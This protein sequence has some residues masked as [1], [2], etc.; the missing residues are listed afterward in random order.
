MSASSYFA[1]QYPSALCSTLI[2]LDFSISEPMELVVKA[3]RE[4]EFGS[5]LQDFLFENFIPNKVISWPKDEAEV[6]SLPHVAGQTEAG[7]TGDIGQGGTLF[8]CR[9]KTC[10]APISNLEKAKKQILT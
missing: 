7:K 2:A 10:L 1:N 4:K 9:N 3:S 6:D 8:L 5:S